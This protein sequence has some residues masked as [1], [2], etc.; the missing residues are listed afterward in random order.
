MAEL[1]DV[2]QTAPSLTALYMVSLQGWTNHNYKSLKD[3]SVLDGSLVLV[4]ALPEMTGLKWLTIEYPC[5][6]PIEISKAVI[7]PGLTALHCHCSWLQMLETPALDDLTLYCAD[8]AEPNFSVMLSFMKRLSCNLLCFTIVGA[9]A[10][11]VVDH[12]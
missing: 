1:Y 9:E 5:N 10:A 3:L 12:I 2:F 6:S 7:H 4:T 11:I 8:K